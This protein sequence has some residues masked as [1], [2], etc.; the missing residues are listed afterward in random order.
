MA[1]ELIARNTLQLHGENPPNSIYLDSRPVIASPT[2][3]KTQCLC[4]RDLRNRVGSCHF[5]EAVWFLV[6]FYW[7]KFAV[8]PQAISLISLTC[9]LVHKYLQ[10]SLLL[11]TA[12]VALNMAA[13]VLPWTC[14]LRGLR[15]LPALA[16]TKENYKNGCLY[17][18]L[19]KIF[20]AVSEDKFAPELCIAFI[21]LRYIVCCSASSFP[22]ASSFKMSEVLGQH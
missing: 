16:L 14:E 3:E 5:S 1:R 2:A 17:L 22:F 21:L 6:L 7:W 10:R 9:S 15:N 20:L 8:W 18:C 12:Q 11:L 19:W 13:D 4:W